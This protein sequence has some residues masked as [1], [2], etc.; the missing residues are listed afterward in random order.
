MA[1]PLADEPMSRHY[2]DAHPLEP[3]PELPPA[4]DAYGRGG[5]I[6]YSFA[7][8]DHCRVVYAVIAAHALPESDVAAWEWVKLW[9]GESV[10]RAR[11]AADAYR[12][13]RIAVESADKE[14][15]P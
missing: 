15:R 2:A 11:E 9:A 4:L 1:H 14:A 3:I 10:T 12:E 13:R 6:V 5:L 7:W 8:C